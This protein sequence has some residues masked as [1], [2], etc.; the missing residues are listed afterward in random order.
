[1]SEIIKDF[2]DDFLEVLLIL[3]DNIFKD[4]NVATLA[5]VEE[6][7]E[8]SVNVIPFPTIKSESSERQINCVKLKN[9][10]LTKNDIVIVVFCDR[11]FIQNLKQLKQNQ[12]ITQLNKNV[13]LHSDKYG[14]ILG[15][16]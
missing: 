15:V 5:I 1:M 4:L 14:V 7:K 3:K 8:D 11:N 10:E 12:K 16:L 13:N 2:N 6:V 9:L